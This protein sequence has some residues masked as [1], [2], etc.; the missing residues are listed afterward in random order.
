VTVTCDIKKAISTTTLV[1]L[2]FICS[3]QQNVLHK[4][5]S[6]KISNLSRLEAL[7]QLQKQTGLNLV[8][9]S[10]IFNAEPKLTY[11]FEQKTVEYVLKK[12]L[13]PAYVF[14]VTETQIV[15]SVNPKRY[16]AVS[17]VI[18]DALSKEP[19][20]GAF[21]VVNGVGGTTTN[22]AG[23]Y[24]IVLPA[25]TYQVKFHYIGYQTV[26]QKIVLNTNV[27]QNQFLNVSSSLNEV[28][29][30]EENQRLNQYG[31]L[32][33]IS[34]ETKE[35]ER[36]P[37]LLGE[38]D[39]LRFFQQMPGVQKGN[40]G[41]NGLYVRGG[42]FDQNLILL[43]DATLYNVNHVTGLY[44]LFT[45]SEVK[46]AD[47]N[48]GAFSARY[49]GR[50][51]SVMDISLR[52]GDKSKFGGEASVG[53]IS[54]RIM[55]QGPIIK[56]KVSF[57]F[58]A[59]RTYVDFVTK[60]FLESDDQVLTFYFYDIHAKVSADLTKSS[61]LTLSTYFGS[62]KYGSKEMQD[63]SAFKSE[64]SWGNRMASIKYQYILGAKSFFNV[65]AS[66][67][68]YYSLLQLI[69]LSNSGKQGIDL[70]STVEDLSAK[71]DWEYSGFN[72]HKIKSGVSFIRHQFN[73]EGLLQILSFQNQPDLL[74][75]ADEG[76][77]YVEDNWQ[78]NTKTNLITGLRGSYFSSSNKNYFNPEPRITL[79][80]IT[81]NNWQFMASASIM[82]Q[83]VNGVRTIS[84]LLPND[85]WIPLSPNQK[86]I[87]ANQYSMSVRKPVKNYEFSTDVFYKKT[88]NAVTT[89]EGSAII[90][91]PGFTWEQT[92]DLL[93]TQGNAEAYGIEFL[94]RKHTG[95]LTGWISY[96]LS[97]VT[98]HFDDINLGR[99]HPA[100][101]DRPHDLGINLRYAITKK[102]MFSA[103]WVYGS[104]NPISLPVG[105]YTSFV[106]T[107]SGGVFGSNLVLDYDGKNTYR[108]IPFHRLDCSIQY[109]TKLAKGTSTFELGAYNAYNRRNALMYFIDTNND[110]AR[111]KKS[112][113]LP[114]I[115][116]ISWAFKF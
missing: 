104:G 115:P 19:L 114:I 94:I 62:D 59:R 48:K 88:T 61:K 75:T 41:D 113:F 24:S 11:H 50:V 83:Y 38:R 56:D 12:I 35:V 9:S 96:T 116:S 98:F 112:S 17:G 52:D 108:M 68:D 89:R 36:L 4:T 100:R 80:H 76:G 93:L 6:F 44:S 87:Y 60:P 30:V 73:P 13:E 95:R 103:A 92:S 25:D 79:Q 39:M 10:D 40:E 18:K 63:G 2:F 43:D 78:L 55:L 3:A 82:Y 26:E 85:I 77:I 8:Y 99:P 74:T 47:L 7:M 65:S 58:S 91:Q 57:L 14:N 111:V 86:P 102:W 37:V 107:P 16:Y 97:K 84:Y 101:F 53:L 66:Y 46:K 105:Q 34:I 90:F 42:S 54:S 72:K 23:Y 109:Q 33:K 20:I 31:T 28:I 32:S 81:K 106:H 110:F 64:L 49:G 70:R 21:V 29:I 51:S 27:V 22:A 5:I 71:A 15:I 67:S 1:L 45:G 69:D